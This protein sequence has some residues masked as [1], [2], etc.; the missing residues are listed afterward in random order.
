MRR[1]VRPSS[2]AVT[3]T[4]GHR[5]Q[6]DTPVRNEESSDS[7]DATDRATSSGVPT[8][9]IGT[10]AFHSRWTGMQGVWEI[11]P[12]CAG[13]SRPGSGPTS[14][15]RATP[16]KRGWHMPS[17][18]GMYR[19]IRAPTAPPLRSSSSTGRGVRPL[20]EIHGTSIADSARPRSPLMAGRMEI[21][22][23]T[24]ARRGGVLTCRV[25]GA[26]A[27]MKLWIK[28]PQ[29]WRDHLI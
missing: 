19:D 13:S 5:R 9:P 24:S 10:T 16:N 2:R 7:R 22:S 14:H 26:P 18:D 4:S 23:P 27:R 29:L 15:R 28:S 21:F 17:G 8:R 3:R 12:A 1:P 25:P 6:A 11:V 20:S